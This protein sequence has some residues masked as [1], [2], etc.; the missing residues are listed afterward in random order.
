MSVTAT[1]FIVATSDTWLS[2]NGRWMRHFAGVEE[3]KIYRRK[4]AALRFI[5]YRPTAFL[6]E[7]LPGDIIYADRTIHRF[8]KV[9]TI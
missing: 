9:E 7:V 6:V 5:R 3:V 1:G 4:A 2:V 8:R